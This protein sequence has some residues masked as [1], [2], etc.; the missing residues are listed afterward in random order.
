MG[1]HKKISVLSLKRERER[2]NEIETKAAGF[3]V[4]G[5]GLGPE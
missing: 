5:L 4:K 3:N 1:K 2:V